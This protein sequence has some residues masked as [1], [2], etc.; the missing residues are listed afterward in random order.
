M[1]SFNLSIGRIL[2]AGLILP[3]L[4]AIIVIARPLA[5]QSLDAAEQSCI[6]AT[7]DVAALF[8]SVNRC[9]QANAG[10]DL[11]VQLNQLVA[12]DAS[13][14]VDLDGHALRFEWFLVEAPKG[15]AAAAN[16]PSSLRTDFT[17][18]LA[19]DYVFELQVTDKAGAVARDRVTFSTNNVPPV[20]QTSKD[21]TVQVG[22]MVS[23]DAARSYDL[24]GDVLAYQWTLVEQPKTSS[25]SLSSRSADRSSLVLDSEGDYRIELKVNDRATSSAGSEL[26]L[27][28]H[29]S[30][31]VAN[32]GRARTVGPNSTIIFNSS[33]S[34]DFDE[35]AL[36]YHWSVLSAPIGY[37]GTFDN[38]SIDSPAITVGTQGLYL[39]QLVVDD[40]IAVSNPATTLIEVKR[41]RIANFDLN[42]YLPL[43]SRAGAVDTDG[44]GI[45]DPVDN[46]VLVANAAQ[47]DTDG[48][49]IGNFCDADLNN[50]GIVNFVD[51]TLFTPLF[52]SSDPDADF[53]GDGNVNFI[54]YF[55]ITNAFLT[56]PGPPG[57]IVWVSLVDGDFDERT[58][59]QP[60]IVPS[61]G[62]TA[63]I[64]VGPAVTV[65]QSGGSITV[66]NLVQ[67]ENMVLASTTVEA[68]GSIQLGG[69]MSA[70]SATTI[71]NTSIQPSL[72]GTGSLTLNAGVH[73]W[74]NNTIGVPT[75]INN[76]ANVNNFNNL[77]VED[78]ISINPLNQFT[79]L[80]FAGE[81]TIF[82][83]AGT[84]LINGVN[85][86]IALNFLRPTSGGTLTLGA[87]LTVVGRNGSVGAASGNLIINGTV[88]ADLAGEPI[89]LGGAV[90][91]GNGTLS[92]QNGS[93]INMF[94]IRDNSAGALNLDTT[95]G[96]A[97]NLLSGSTLRNGAVTGTAGSNLTISP[98]TVNLESV[99]YNLD[100]LMSNGAN[101]NV[102]G[103]LTVNSTV[104]M[105][106]TNQFTRLLFPETQTVG[107]SGTIV[108]TGSG[109]ITLKSLLPQGA[110][111]VVTFGEDL[112]IRGGLG[113]V[114][115]ASSNFIVDGSINADV[116]GETIQILGLNWSS[117]ST[118]TA[119][120]N[121][122]L[123]LGGNFDN[124]GNTL[125]LDE[126]T[127]GA[128]N[129]V[130]GTSLRNVTV[131]GTPGTNLTLNPGGNTNLEAV[132]FNLDV[133]MANGANPIVTEGLTINST[134]LMDG[135]NQFTRLL[136]PETQTVG[137]TGTIVFADTGSITL[138]SLVPQGADTVLTV[139]EDLTIRGGF[140][141]VGSASS[142]TLIDG[143][144]N[145][146]VDGQSIQI[147]GLTWSSDSTLTASNNGILLLAGN[148]DNGGNTL[149]LDENTGGAINVVNGT[150]LR[151]ATIT[152]TPGTNLTLNAGGNTNLES[153]VFD[154]DV[155]L[156][157]GGN[158]IVTGGLTINSTFLVDGI[159]QFTRLLFP[160]SQAVGGS[161]SI[162][163]AESGSTTLKAL[164][165]QGVDTVVTFAEE[166]TIRGGAGTIGST[167][168]NTIMSGNVNADVDGQAIQFVGS[169]IWNTTSNVTASN[170]G[171]IIL[172]GSFDNF[173][174]LN[175]DTTSGG[176]VNVANGSSL[177]NGTIVGTTGTNLTLNAG[178]NTNLETMVFDID[179][180]WVNGANHI[181]T[182]GLT[183]NR[184]W[185][186][187]GI[188][189]F[190]RLLFPETQTIGGSGTIVFSSGSSITLKGLL[191]QGP[192]T[193]LT[194]GSGITIRGGQ[195]TIG[196]TVSDLII[197]GTISADTGSFNLVGQSIENNGLLE[198]LN[199]HTLSLDNLAASPGD[200]H[201]GPESVLQ[202]L[203][204]IA[205]LNASSDVFLDVGPS[206]VP[207]SI[208]AVF[209]SNVLDGNL[210]V[211]AVDGYMPPVGTGFTIIDQDGPATGTFATENSL[212]L[213]AGESFS[214]NYGFDV[215]AT[216]TN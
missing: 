146:D 90:W 61:A 214:I 120:N 65:T 62:S 207:G 103:G 83:N 25:A 51:I 93:T 100:V 152:G 210:T 40:G 158:P 145:A 122:T 35:N 15:S 187:D 48:D 85:G 76:G 201:A 4:L 27:S 36:S 212:G 68:G 171:G 73:T 70:L 75:E 12:L 88:L 44:D 186:V 21:L 215:T 89:S 132:V 30:A 60:Q 81:Q 164:L 19:G 8:D 119:S 136:F 52:Q 151:N 56:Q 156:V 154:L 105:N 82:G 79:G 33:R 196:S 13:R 190:T 2:K 178:G 23:L 133:T 86:S 135:I 189:Q 115:S 18:D 206:G 6:T 204:A 22:Q 78:T 131:T 109:S 57:T 1:N 153:L 179:V 166:L 123:L 74:S 28:T 172:N 176:T 16:E 64:D 174:T 188:N 199:G 71:N 66:E 129:V 3:P 106:A 140:G 114:G 54:D 84:I 116:D 163:F 63:I 167:T 177:R 20:A 113:T 17:P 92:V 157:N 162:V 121:A 173:G 150:S 11:P 14:T 148:F 209:D 29:N 208:L 139:G 111:T 182:G 38:A 58:N 5:A 95:G 42:D 45:A 72:A 183:I 165:P 170:N 112:T 126:N 104:F 137:G 118:L 53:N 94:G 193:V 141:T 211:S 77:M 195:A 107:G 127:G 98:G 67:N 185:T 97:I 160:E 169:T 7:R 32:A 134:L 110:D 203:D 59:W 202:F 180:T 205:A 181:I 125:N 47:R 24:D 143:S 197:E 147:L 192:D 99:I 91:S 46:C 10:M 168:S 155:T 138:K 117:D 9:P 41:D 194:I 175:L 191:P 200:L 34:E 159:N 213:G 108:F 142:N 87:G 216:V 128:I 26:V 102:T 55:I 49:G 124:G 130:N 101:S 80:N 184:T 39:V 31:P 144:I 37:K 96:G 149:N 198:V 161:G 50:D 43:V 69:T